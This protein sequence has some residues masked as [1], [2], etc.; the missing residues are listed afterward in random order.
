MFIPMIK[1]KNV[2]L[3]KTVEQNVYTRSFHIKSIKVRI[4][5]ERNYIL[6]V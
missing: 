1:N 5:K 4:N 6:H 3:S 2:K